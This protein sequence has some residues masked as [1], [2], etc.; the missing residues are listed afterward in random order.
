[1]TGKIFEYLAARRPLLSVAPF[2]SGIDEILVHFGKNALRA[3][4]T[5]E[6]AEAALDILLTSL[7]AG[8]DRDLLPAPGSAVKF[9]RRA[10]ARQL[11]NLVKRLHKGAAPR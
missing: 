3:D 10:S 8:N 6:A 2:P 9:S 11:A 7:E 1:V 4:D 5:P